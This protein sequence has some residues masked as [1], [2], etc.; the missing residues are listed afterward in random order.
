MP[1]HNEHARQLPFPMKDGHGNTRIVWVDES[2]HPIL[3]QMDADLEQDEYAWYHTIDFRTEAEKTLNDDGDSD[4]DEDPIEN[5]PDETYSPEYVI[6]HKKGAE[7]FEAAE[8]GKVRLEIEITHKAMEILGPQQRELLQR[9]MTKTQRE[10]AEEDGVKQQ[11]I[12]NREMK[13]RRRVKAE[14][15]K[16]GIDDD[17]FRRHR[18]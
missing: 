17:Y 9:R 11:A 6:F 3:T 8:E 2:I 7:E 4:Y 16:D 14:L 15:E 10:I 1:D 12:S 18:R 5:L 13:I